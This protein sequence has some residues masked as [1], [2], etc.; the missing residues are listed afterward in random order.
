MP[1]MPSSH[2]GV[3][4]WRGGAF[5]WQEGLFL[6]VTIQLCLQWVVKVGVWLVSERHISSLLSQVPRSQQR[7]ELTTQV[8]SLFPMAAFS[9]RQ[10]AA[11]R[12]PPGPTSPL[13]CPFP[14]CVPLDSATGG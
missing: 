14:V 4:C 7:R 6:P 10:E 12:H 2:I 1:T 5:G 9:G 3:E 11:G 13:L 8:S